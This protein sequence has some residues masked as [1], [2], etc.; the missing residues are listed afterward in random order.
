ML[1]G[2]AQ[3]ALLPLAALWLVCAATVVA[4][5]VAQELLEGLLATGHPAGLTGIF[6]YGGWWAIPATVAVGLV[7]AVVLH[8]ARWVIDEVARRR[9]PVRRAAHQPLPRLLPRQGWVRACSRSS[10]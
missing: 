3:V 6:G 5:F 7:V 4:I 1:H 2:L 8:G 10:P 9:R